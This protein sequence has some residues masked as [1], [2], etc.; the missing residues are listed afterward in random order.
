[1]ADSRGGDL[2]LN[3]DTILAPAEAA[4][5]GDSTELKHQDSAEKEALQKCL[6]NQNKTLQN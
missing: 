3:E 6:S 5:E 1:M 4:G 2:Q